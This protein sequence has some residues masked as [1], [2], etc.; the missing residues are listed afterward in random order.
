VGLHGV[1]WEEGGTERAEVYTFFY[2]QGNEEHQLGTGF[3]VHKKIVSAVRRVEFIS[4]KM[5]YIILR[6]LWCN[7]VVL[8]VHA[9]CEDESD[10]AK[11]SL[12]E[13]LWLVFDQFPRHDMKRLFSDFNTE[14]VTG[15]IFK[16]AIG[17][18]SSHEF[19]KGSGVR[20]VNLAKSRNLVVKSVIFHVAAF[21]NTNLPL[22][23]ERC[24]TRL[25]IDR[26]R[27]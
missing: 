16:L 15:H 26:R 21:I 1:A 7:I 4:D 23:K 13:E 10:D 20:V 11:D 8:K 5:P 19:S 24:T 6:G 27:H 25:H 17:N 18:E 9:S 22:L 2:E 3:F 12:C 14:V